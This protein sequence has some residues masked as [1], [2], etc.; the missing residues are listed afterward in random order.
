MTFRLSDGPLFS[1]FLSGQISEHDSI[2]LTLVLSH[3]FTRYI[4]NIPVII[5]C[6]NVIFINRDDHFNIQLKINGEK[7]RKI[8]KRCSLYL[9]NLKIFEFLIFF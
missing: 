3:L 1:P 5:L 9:M 8:L 4:Y 7:I 2:L 6:H